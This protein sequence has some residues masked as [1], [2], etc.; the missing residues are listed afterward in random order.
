MTLAAAVVLTSIT[1][2]GQYRLWVQTENEQL[3]V[4]SHKGNIE[5][6]RRIE[7]QRW[8]PASKVAFGSWSAEVTSDEQV[9]F[10]Y[11]GEKPKVPTNVRELAKTFEK[12]NFGA[13]T[14][15]IVGILPVAETWYLFVSW[16]H[17]QLSGQPS[18]GAGVFEIV[19]NGAFNPKF[20]RFLTIPALG[21]GS[22]VDILHIDEKRITLLSGKRLGEPYQELL[23][24]D[25]AALK[26]IV[27][28][29]IVD[30]SVANDTLLYFADSTAATPW[31]WDLERSRAVRYVTRHNIRGGKLF[32]SAGRLY[33]LTEGKIMLLPNGPSANILG[34]SVPHE[35]SY[36]IVLQRGSNLALFDRL[37]LKRVY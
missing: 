33:S 27:T 21:Y 37:T 5:K 19:I 1:A 24:V 36:G 8:S 22:R 30:P 17:R 28:K 6:C 11:D 29:K 18:F 25:R 13:P 16:D 3:V 23:V 7:E 9:T 10:R 14:F 32:A 20:K 15:R 2:Q 35:C 12:R 34:E 4:V 26:L 31:R